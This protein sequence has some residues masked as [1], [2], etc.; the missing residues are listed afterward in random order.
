M[1]A[2]I[3]FIVDSWIKL[4][5]GVGGVIV[6]IL[7]IYRSGYS[8][9]SKK[10]WERAEEAN[11]KV[12]DKHKQIADEIDAVDTSKLTDDEINAELQKTLDKGK[13]K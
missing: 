5:A 11:K 10:A 8:K 4:A 3:K 9:G 2:I 13:A 7:L 1:T 12:R 6:T